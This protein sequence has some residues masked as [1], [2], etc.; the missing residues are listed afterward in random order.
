MRSICNEGSTIRRYC[1]R[2][3]TGRT[4]RVRET[5][6]LPTIAPRKMDTS[7]AEKMIPT[8]SSFPKKTT[9]NSRIKSTCV[10][11]EYAPKRKKAMR[12]GLDFRKAGLLI[13]GKG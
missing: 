13:S 3:K 10:A 12:Y 2:I 7:Q 9:K 8:Q 11:I 6:L 1:N 5:V 4:L